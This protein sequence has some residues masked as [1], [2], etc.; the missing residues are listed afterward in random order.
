[1]EEIEAEQTNATQK[2]IPA[3]N[4]SQILPSSEQTEQ[5]LIPLPSDKDGLSEV[6]SS[7]LETIT[8]D[9]ILSITELYSRLGISDYQ[10]N[11]SKNSLVQKGFVTCVRLPRL[12]GKGRSPETLALT[13]KGM[14]F[15]R[16]LG[17]NV[18]DS[19]SS[20]GLHHRYIVQRLEDQ[21]RDLGW[22]AITEYELAEGRRTDILVNDKV[23]I[24][25]EMGKSEIVENVK[26]NLEAGF[27]VI[28]VSTQQAISS[29]IDKLAKQGLGQTRV[30]L[31][32][33]VV[34]CVKE[35]LTVTAE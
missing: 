23:A 21:F 13:D 16:R 5:I 10:A 25:V 11:K 29:V 12:S 2:P 9:K 17:K 31:P 33:Q 19:R 30:V 27:D 28:V 1:M 8:G 34:L 14:Q 7:I 3:D 35:R 15:A 18:K 6:E 22:K 20:G 24:E 26:K 32:D 4:Q